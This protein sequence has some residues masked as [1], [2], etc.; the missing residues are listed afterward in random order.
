MRALL[1][2]AH[3]LPM[4][5]A[6]SRRHWK[7]SFSRIQLLRPLVSLGWLPVESRMEAWSRDPGP[8]GCVV[9]CIAKTLSR[10]V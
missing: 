1:G 5:L 7:G 3:I 9:F 10:W 6:Q 2:V 8:N 4:G